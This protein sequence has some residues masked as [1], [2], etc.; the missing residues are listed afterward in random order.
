MGSVLS[1]GVWCGWWAWRS[2]RHD[3]RAQDLCSTLGP[4]LLWCFLDM[5]F[6]KTIEG[7]PVTLLGLIICAE[8]AHCLIACIVWWVWRCVWGSFWWHYE[9]FQ[10]RVFH[11]HMF[12]TNDKR[13]QSVS[14]PPWAIDLLFH[15]NLPHFF[16]S[17]SF[18]RYVSGISVDS[19]RCVFADCFI[20]GLLEIVLAHFSWYLVYI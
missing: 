19:C 13:Q 5:P 4:V 2:C 7:C 14:S 6:I 8:E 9:G 20:C 1:Q 11:C 18:C 17:T 10:V 3:L 12:H 15:Y 16:L